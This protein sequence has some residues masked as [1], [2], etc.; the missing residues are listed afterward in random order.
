MYDL[1]KEVVKN[2]EKKT[3]TSKIEENKID[4]DH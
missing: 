4:S 2:E 1:K 3:G